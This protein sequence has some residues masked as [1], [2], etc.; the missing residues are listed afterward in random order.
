MRHIGRGVGPSGSQWCNWPLDLS[1][2]DPGLELYIM[3]F[4]LFNVKKTCAL[5]KS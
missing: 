4:L 3:I 2:I 5:V 1:R